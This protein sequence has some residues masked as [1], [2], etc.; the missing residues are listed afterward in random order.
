MRTHKLLLNIESADAV[1]TGQKRFDIRKN[2]ADYQTGDFIEYAVTD[3]DSDMTAD[4]AEAGMAE[5]ALNGRLY[6]IDYILSGCGLE[7]GYVAL[8]ISEAKPKENG[9]DAQKSGTDDGKVHAHW[10]ISHEGGKRT[11]VCSACQ[12]KRHGISKS[13]YCRDCGAVMDEPCER[14]PDTEEYEKRPIR[15]RTKRRKH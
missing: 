10:I 6:R 7:N 8:S 9:A 3:I 4:K 5:H 15:S 14:R 12:N 2:D 13:A 1:M 11:F